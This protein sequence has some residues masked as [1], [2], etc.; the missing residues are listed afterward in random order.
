MRI[1]YD[2]LVGLGVMPDVA[3]GIVNDLSMRRMQGQESGVEVDDSLTLENLKGL[4][5]SDEQATG[6]M[7]DAAMQRHQQQQNAMAYEAQQAGI[8]QERAAADEQGAIRADQRATLMGRKEEITANLEALARRKIEQQAEDDFY[9]EKDRLMLAYGAEQADRLAKQQEEDAFDADAAARQFVANVPT[10]DWSRGEQAIPG[11]AYDTYETP[12][13]TRVLLE[14][15]AQ[16]QQQQQEA[17]A[18]AARAA[19]LATLE[20]A[21][22][23]GQQQ[24]DSLTNRAALQALMNASAPIAPRNFGEAMKG[25]P[26]TAQAEMTQ[27]IN[28]AREFFGRQGKVQRGKMKQLEAERRMQR[29]RDKRIPIARPDVR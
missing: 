11:V 5:M 23:T 17:K 27:N 8:A 28:L 20:T 2:T 19:E 10:V 1:E 26:T 18:K 7:N 16:R 6:L 29:H 12:E 3:R 13:S 24:V 9:T 4:G 14:G 21:V 22:N 25:T 15:G